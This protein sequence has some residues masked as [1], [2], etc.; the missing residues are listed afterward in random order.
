LNFYKDLA[1]CT[2]REVGN[3][4]GLNEDIDAI[5]DQFKQGQ[6]Q[7]TQ[8]QPGQQQS[9]NTNTNNN[10]NNLGNEENN[11][12]TQTQSCF[13]HYLSYFRCYLYLYSHFVVALLTYKFQLEYW[14]K[15]VKVVDFFQDQF[16]LA[17]SD[18]EALEKDL[19]NYLLFLFLICIF[20]FVFCFLK[21][22]TLN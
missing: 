17:N 7:T 19:Y 10:E 5:A 6:H 21:T 14:I 2:L 9:G 3:E 15:R 18:Q 20:H 8:Q 22:K 12:G 16:C 13:L 1:A 11:S 4:L